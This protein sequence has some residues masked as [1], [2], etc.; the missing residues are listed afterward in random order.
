MD[1]CGGFPRRAVRG[2]VEGC[3]GYPSHKISVRLDLAVRP[4]LGVTEVDMRGKEE[5]KCAEKVT[6]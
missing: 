1:G 3:S 6:N 2:S 4:W 5:K